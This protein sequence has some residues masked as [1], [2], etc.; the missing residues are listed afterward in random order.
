MTSNNKEMIRFAGI[1]FII[2][3]FFTSSTAIHTL[4]DVSMVGILAEWAYS[5]YKRIR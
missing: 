4:A 1:C 2:G 5:S 3:S